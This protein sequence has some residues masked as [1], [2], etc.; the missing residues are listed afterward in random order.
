[1]SIYSS[2]KSSIN[3]KSEIDK[4]SLAIQGRQCMFPVCLPPVLL[5]SCGSTFFMF[6]FL[7]VF[8]MYECFACSGQKRALDSLELEF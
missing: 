4:H 1:M 8:D 6:F 2:N 7:D 3:Q 5:F